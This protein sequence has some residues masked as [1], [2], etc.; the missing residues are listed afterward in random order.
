MRIIRRIVMAVLVLTVL[1]GIG[2]YVFQKVKYPYGRSHNCLVHLKLA[3]L[4]YAMDHEGRFPAGQATPE[5][6]LSLLHKEGHISASLLRGMTA[7]PEKVDAILT[8][9][10]LLGPDTCGW[11][12]VEGLTES[13]DPEI[14]ILWCKEPLGHYG[15][16]TKDKSREV[17]FVDGGY[18]SIPGD[19]WDEFLKE[20]ERLLAQRSTREKAGFPLVNATVISPEGETINKHKGEYRH[21]DIFKE[22]GST[23]TNS[24]S[25]NPFSRTSLIIHRAPIQNGSL[26]R[27]ISFSEYIS[28]PVTVSFSDGVASPTNVVFPMRR[29]PWK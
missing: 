14:A 26:T 6:S 8:K 22:T 24:G 5:A 27:V 1:G 17:L 23:W 2:A 11:H 4:M 13:A 7:P 18:K 19:K 3:F 25:G 16:R 21:Q 10:E 12:Y 20:Q 9:G 28:E 15:Q 29:K